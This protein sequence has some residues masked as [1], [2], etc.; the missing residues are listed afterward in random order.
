MSFQSGFS[1]TLECHET[2]GSTSDYCKNEAENGAAH[3]RAVLAYCQTAGRG[4]RGRQW[5]APSGN[6]SFSFIC[7]DARV[8]DL[9]QAMPF[10]VAVA[11]HDAL[12]TCAPSAALRIKWPNDILC[13][14]A[15][16]AGVLIERGGATGSEWIVVGIGANLKTAPD[17]AGRQTVALSALG[18]Q[19]GPAD[20]ARQIL[21]CFSFWFDLW[22]RRG[23]APIRQAWL[24]RAHEPGSRLAVQRGGDYIEGFFAG[25]DECGRL[26]LQT[27]QNEVQTVAAGDILLLG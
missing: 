3:G 12:S 8:N 15:K 13:D 25:L 23:F 20:L 6:L 16:L 14:G 5:D 7:R 21:T 19:V 4:T 24:D 10:M 26:V 9:V 17:I 11:V 2:L 1:W 18:G 27:D 22:Q